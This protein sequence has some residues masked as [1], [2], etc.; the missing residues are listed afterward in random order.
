MNISLLM[1]K[2]QSKKI[3]SAFDEKVQTLT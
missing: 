1:Q 2:K 3:H